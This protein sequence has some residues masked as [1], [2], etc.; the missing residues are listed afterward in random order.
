MTNQIV[1]WFVATSARMHKGD[2]SIMVM[3]KEFHGNLP[4]DRVY[5]YLSAFQLSER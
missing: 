2:S 4:N 5:L 1:D 3:D